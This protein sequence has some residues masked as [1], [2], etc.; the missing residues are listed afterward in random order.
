M[1]I[2]WDDVSENYSE[3]RTDRVHLIVKRQGKTWLGFAGRGDAGRYEVSIEQPHLMS[4]AAAK[5]WAQ[6]HAHLVE[7]IR[8]GEAA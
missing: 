6:T 4:R 3:A 8:K 1:T 2:H 7:P 5:E